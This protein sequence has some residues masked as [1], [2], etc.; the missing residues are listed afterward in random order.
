M[1]LP[2]MRCQTPININIKGSLMEFK[3]KNLHQE[4]LEEQRLNKFKY[5]TVLR[6]FVFF[7]TVYRYTIVTTEVS[8]AEKNYSLKRSQITWQRS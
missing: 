6:I 5:Q 8:S 4:R 2:N 7:P 3:E 1:T